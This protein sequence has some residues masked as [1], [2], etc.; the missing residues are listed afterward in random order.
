MKILLILGH[1]DKGSFNH[2]IAESVKSTL[3]KMGHQVM[4][5]DLYAEGFEPI[6]PPGEISASGKV[7]STIKTHCEELI[8]AD[9]IIIV[10]PNW[11]G[12]PPA[13]IKGWIDRV[14]R[15]R[16]AYRFYGTTEAGIPEGLLKAK[17]ALVFNTSNTFEEREKAHFGDPLENLWKICVWNFCGV[18]KFF[19][20]TFSVI[21]ESSLEQR[22]Q[23]LKEVEE[24]V[25]KEFS[26]SP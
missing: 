17:T 18:K 7:D 25:T 12:Q 22:K 10:H 16:I 14:L 26:S 11:W 19:R 6:L 20:K 23:W 24:L 4:F 5:H 3:L 15:P 8:S 21:V 1:P 13:I 2:A 9:G